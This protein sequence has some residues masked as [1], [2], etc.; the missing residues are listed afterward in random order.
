MLWVPGP[1]AGAVL[2]GT[3]TVVSVVKDTTGDT[4]GTSTGATGAL[5]LPLDGAG[6]L[7]A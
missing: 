4:E 6:P 1:P 2:V 3:C 5:L 7:L